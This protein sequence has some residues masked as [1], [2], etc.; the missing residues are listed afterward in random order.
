MRIAL[1]GDSA[2]GNLAAVVAHHARDTGRVLK[3]QLLIY[4]ATDTRTDTASYNEN[5]EGYS[6]ERAGMEWFFDQYLPDPVHRTDPRMAVLRSPNFRYLAPALILTAGY[7]PLRDDG[8]LYATALHDAGTRVVLQEHDTL[9][10][11]FANML[12][13]S[14]VSRRAILEAGRLVG[15]ALRV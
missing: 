13:V 9:I 1:A 4:P 7:D 10:H 8:R 14:D 6:L 12:G 2:G 5:A 3:F 11:G 15:E